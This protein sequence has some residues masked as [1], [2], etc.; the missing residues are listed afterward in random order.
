MAYINHLCCWYMS[1][2][3]SVIARLCAGE[4]EHFALHLRGER[5]RKLLISSVCYVPLSEFRGNGVLNHSASL[6]VVAVGA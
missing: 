5:E 3:V 2:F 1:R 4:P 6:P